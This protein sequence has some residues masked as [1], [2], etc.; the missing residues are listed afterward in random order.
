MQWYFGAFS[1]YAVFQGRARRSEYWFFMLFYFIGLFVLSFVDVMLGTFPDSA[2][3]GILGSIFAIGH[4][5]PAISLQVRRLHDTGRSGW[6]SLLVL[7]PILG[8]LVL[9]VFMVG[10]GEYQ[11]N[12]WGANPKA[13]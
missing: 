2:S 8:S 13:A 4:F 7:I 11:A 3:I 12:Y 5:L 1:K 9:F 10:E 6:W